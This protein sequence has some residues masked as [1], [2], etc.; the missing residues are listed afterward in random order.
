MRERHWSTKPDCPSFPLAAVPRLVSQPCTSLETLAAIGEEPMQLRAFNQPTPTLTLE[1]PSDHTSKF[2]ALTSMCHLS[3]TPKD[4]DIPDCFKFP[5]AVLAA[6]NLQPPQFLF[7]WRMS[8]LP[9]D[10]PLSNLRTH[11]DQQV[12]NFGIG[13]NPHKPRVGNFGP[14]K[15]FSCLFSLLQHT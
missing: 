1:S 13:C 11:F 5:P 2:L 10:S 4:C 12:K 8:W 7:Q 3:E 15:P 6:P 14:R 9:S